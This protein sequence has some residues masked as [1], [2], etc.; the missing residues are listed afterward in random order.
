MNSRHRGTELKSMVLPGLE[1]LDVLLLGL[2]GAAGAAAAA[3]RAAVP[4][5]P[6]L[7]KHHIQCVTIFFLDM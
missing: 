5:R 1:G 7:R 3:R 2:G 4:Q 6:F